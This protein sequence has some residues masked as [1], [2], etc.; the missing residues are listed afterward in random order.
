[1][2]DWKRAEKLRVFPVTPNT[3]EALAPL[4][5]LLNVIAVEEVF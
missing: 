1:M 5:V 2:T 4:I 3:V